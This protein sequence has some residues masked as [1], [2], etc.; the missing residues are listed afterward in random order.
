MSRAIAH[1]APNTQDRRR[2][3]CTDCGE[4]FAAGDEIVEPRCPVCLGVRVRP[5][6]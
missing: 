6:R 1:R 3:A 4:E 5:R 2:Y